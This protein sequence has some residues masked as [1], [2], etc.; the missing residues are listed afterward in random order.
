MS[1]MPYQDVGFCLECAT[2]HARD[3][4]HHLEDAVKFGKSNP[5]RS[6]FQ[7]LLDQQRLIRKELDKMRIQQIQESGE[8]T[9]IACETPAG[10]PDGLGE[11][12]IGGMA[13]GVGSVIGARLMEGG[14]PGNPDNPAEIPEYC[15]FL[16]EQV[17]PKEYFD[18]RSFRTLCPE[19]PTRL[20]KDL[21]PE[22][23]CATR[24]I[25]GCKKGEFVKGR[26]QVG[27]QAHVVYHGRPK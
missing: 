17:K 6:R 18:P 24:I 2:Q 11:A 22:L 7:E 27:T 10:N 3:V 16:K 4:E 23:A 21:P 20:C 1:A 26:C 14:S 9:C 12:V 5:N 25:I 19:S 8:E 15:E 13:A